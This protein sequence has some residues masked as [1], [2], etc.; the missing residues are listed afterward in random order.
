MYDFFLSC[1]ITLIGFVA[2]AGPSNFQEL[3]SPPPV[4][5]PIL[6]H[7]TP[8][9]AAYR[10]PSGVCQVSPLHLQQSPSHQDINCNL[11]DQYIDVKPLPNLHISLNELDEI[12][13][14]TDMMNMSLE[15]SQ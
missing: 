14:L 1:I 2:E 9:P 13:L 12:G 3:H 11:M 15:Q 8:S 6:G 7:Q 5:V 10:S 4:S